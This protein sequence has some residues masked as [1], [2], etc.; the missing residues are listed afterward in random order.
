MPY[1]EAQKRATM[2]YRKNNLV[3]LTLDL[4]PEE[5]ETIKAA[6]VAAGKPVKTYLLDLVRQDT[7]KEGISL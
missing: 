5:K 7:A 3:T 4:K 1:T 2:K 6:A